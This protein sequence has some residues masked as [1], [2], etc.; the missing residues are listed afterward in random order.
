MVLSHVTCT[1]IPYGHCFSYGD[2]DGFPPLLPL[3]ILYL[4]LKLILSGPILLSLTLR[5][6][7]LL[8]GLKQIIY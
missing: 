3:K 8:L 1:W 5:L 7:Y 2:L 4:S 6:P